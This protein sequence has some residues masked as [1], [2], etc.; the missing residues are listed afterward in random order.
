ML[1][2]ILLGI[3]ML[4]LAGACIGWTPKYNI[5]Y[6]PVVVGQQGTLWSIA[7]SFYDSNE[8]YPIVAM[9]FEEYLYN[10]KHDA[11]N[12]QLTANGRVIQAGDIVYV[13]IYK[14]AK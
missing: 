10:V 1:N 12:A 4:V 14:K 8:F 9:C 11:K 2:K 7:D 13:P 3:V 6:V 5:T